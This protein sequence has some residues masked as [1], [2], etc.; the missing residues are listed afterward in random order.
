MLTR[1]TPQIHRLL[2]QTLPIYTFASMRKIGKYYVP[3][4]PAYRI[5]P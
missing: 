4:L 3:D 5:N 1:I 2:Q